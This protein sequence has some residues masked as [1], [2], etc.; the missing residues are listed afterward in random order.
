[1]QN[2]T[3]RRKFLQT[4]AASAGMLAA[5]PLCTGLSSVFT[6]I[7]GELRFRQYPHPW[8]P[9]M[10]WAYASDSN[11]DPF[12]SNLQASK[13]GII[14]PFDYGHDRFSLTTR[15]FVDGFGYLMLTADNGGELYSQKNLNGN[16]EYNLNFEFARSR[17]I[18]NRN[19]RLRYE[20]AGAAFSGEVRHLF[21][22]SEE[23][24]ESADKSAKN[25]EKCAKLADQAL[26]CALRTG[27]KIELEKAQWEIARKT[28]RDTV[29]FGCETRQYIWAKSEEFTRRFPELFNFATV[30][31]YVWDTWYEIFEPREGYYNWG[32]KDNIVN[33]LIDNNIRIQGRPLFWF[34]PVVTPDWLKN[35]NIDELKKYVERHTRDLVSHYGD[36]IQQWSVVNEYHD[37]A[38]IHNHTPEETTE[39]TRLACEKTHEVN[40]RVIR[41][42]NNCCPWADYAPWG[43]MARQKEPAG[44][45][46]RSPRKFMQDLTDAAVPYEVLGIQIYFPRRDLSDIVRLLE[47]FETFGK[48]IYITEIGVT[49]YGINRQ[50]VADPTR[51]AE[52]PYEWHRYW[53]EELQADWLEQVYT[54][55]YSRPAIKAVNWYDFSDFRPFIMNGGLVREDCSTKQSFERMKQLLA[56]WHRLPERESK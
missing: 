44:R 9:E 32:V 37:W 1:M 12:Q 29:Y 6:Q 8:M 19:V 48:P 38:N 26:R 34:H 23:F 43:K 53:D 39:I 49:S 3:T 54:L 33:W 16:K 11:E 55:Y 4:A 52:E 7:S 28:R 2:V 10:S 21:D 35:K 50:A 25:P 40:P 15:W 46:L 56:S 17:I 22:L 45:P 41:I 31:H 20:R 42:I 30:T 18:R 24:F 14:I 27:E 47:R 51:M 13:Q 36:K 5:A